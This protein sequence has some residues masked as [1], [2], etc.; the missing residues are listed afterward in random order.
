MKPD[1]FFHQ[2]FL[3]VDFVGGVESCRAALVMRLVLS[4]F[5]SSA[6]SCS[7]RVC[8]AGRGVVDV[9]CGGDGVAA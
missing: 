5:W 4:F 7:G 6:P 8:G 1:E 3:E 2:A 9:R